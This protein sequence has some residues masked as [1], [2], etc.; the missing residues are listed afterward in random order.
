MGFM[1]LTD[2]MAF[3]FNPPPIQGLGQAG[4]FELYVQGAPTPTRSAW[5]R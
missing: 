1:A 2:G 3:A 4:G 5:R